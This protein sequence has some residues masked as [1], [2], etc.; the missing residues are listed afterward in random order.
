[1]HLNLKNWHALSVDEV[2]AFLKTEKEGLSEEE[3]VHRQKRYG[4]N[5]LPSPK[6]RSAIL[7]FLAQFQHILIYIL[8]ISVLITLV[9]GEW[10]NAGVIFMVILIN[11]VIGFFQEG[12]A[13]EALQVVSKLLPL[14]CLV[15]RENKHRMISAEQLVPGDRVLLQSGDKIPA[16]L[17]LISVDNLRISE[18][19]LTGESLPVE[20]K[21][22]P[23]PVETPISDQANMAFSGTLVSSG[24]GLGVVVGTG[25]ETEIGRITQLLGQI[26][27]PTTPLLH[28]I[29]HFSYWLSLFIFSLVSFL[30]LWGLFFREYT[31]EKILMI[32]VGIAVSAIPE[33]LPVILTITLAIG[34]R[35]M[36]LR[37]AVIRRLP[38]VE[39]LGSVT[40]ICTDKTGTLTR[41]EMTATQVCMA[42]QRFRVTGSGYI[43]YGE[44]YEEERLIE[45]KQ[46]PALMALCKAGILCSES[47]FLE[48]H[49][50]LELQGDPT[51]GALLILGMKAG[52][53][54]KI[55]RKEHPL[56]DIIPF[57]SEHAL[58]ATLH[59]DHD[60]NSVIYVKG[61]PEIIVKFCNK[62]L[63]NQGESSIDLSF[64]DH[65]IKMITQKGQRALAIAFKPVSSVHQVLSFT[66][67]VSGLVLLGIVGIM[68]PP[69]EEA[70]LAIQECQSAGIC[71]KMI[72][73]DHS[74]TARAI[75][76]QMGI[77]IGKK[78]L[79]GEALEKL[80]AIQFVEEA[81]QVDVFARTTAAQKLKLVEALQSKG[82]I[83]A[84][85]G[86]G[87]ND[88][89]ALKQAEIGVAMGL[90][91]SE[92]AKEAAEI[93]LVDDNFASI[94]AAVKEGRTVFDNLK[95]VILFI[96]PT[97]AGEAGSLV[98]AI[99]MGCTLPITA[100]QILW[101]NMVSS[102]VLTMPLAFEPS[103]PQVMSQKATS[104]RNSIGS[105]FLLFQ[106]LLVGVL[107]VAGIFVAFEW[108]LAQGKSLSVARTLAVNSLIILE[109]AYLL[110]IR[111]INRFTFG[112]DGMKNM[113]HA[114]MLAILAVFVFQG[115][116]TYLPFMQWLFNTAAID[117]MG[118]GLVLSIGI[119]GF[120]VLEFAKWIRIKGTV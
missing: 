31:L 43:P 52:Y 88:A 103:D 18:M 27:K 87:V 85:T 28:K 13:E 80:D 10:L 120:I 84:M 59:H 20:K 24:R 71:V 97:N 62:A 21:L 40:V 82:Q 81:E 54:L 77:G 48:K 117:L 95:K 50:H 14:Q 35:R 83:V 76:E 86:D 108:A 64:W 109:V 110:S 25:K 107:F 42:D 47:E 11:A 36:A 22:M 66:D 2:L 53:D 9:L 38:A 115:L 37:N 1:M 29:N 75:A 72:T 61:A 39:A 99:L 69:R 114:L 118:I 49:G 104:E 58:M 5:V 89:P 116:F 4:Y 6:S 34:V 32:S 45:A 41:N 78:V 113:T 7:R 19:I 92:A 16:D 44:F 70:L 60:G 65:Q 94:V 106:V 98:V 112:L 79:T 119:I 15:I 101:V 68:D 12:K 91:G 51:E 8:L 111:S 93:V 26:E 105:R 102:V 30:F 33:G 17:R 23:L 67:V 63:G 96:L 100:L 73:G 56:I 74:F 90:K 3:V 57:E 55:L 46:I